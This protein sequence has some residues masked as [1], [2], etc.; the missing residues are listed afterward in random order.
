MIRKINC[1]LKT[2][3][4]NGGIR[5]VFLPPV[6]KFCRES[7]Q[8]FIQPAVESAKFRNFTDGI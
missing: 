8:E 2:G 3:E 4:K 1:G 7:A 5:H 6:L